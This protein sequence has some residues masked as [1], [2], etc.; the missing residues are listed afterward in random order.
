V[1]R[2]LLACCLLLAV[3][4][5]GPQR[6]QRVLLIG[7][8]LTLA[9]GLGAMIEA[10]AR[11]AGDPPI[12][13]RT[14]AIGGYS[15]ED[16]WTQGEARR[17]LAAGGWS[18]V[19]LQ[20]GPSSLP[21]SRDLLREYAGRF[22]VRVRRAGARTALFMVWPPAA[23]PG[24]YA[25]V[26]QS[27]R[28]A[29]ADVHGLLLPVGDAFRAALEK[30]PRTPL[31]GTDGFHPSPLGTYLAAVVIYQ[32]LAHRPEPFVSPT[33]ESPDGRFPAIVLSP[34][35]VALF[36]AAARP[37]PPSSRSWRANTCTASGCFQC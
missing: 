29:A 31:F 23:G 33:L 20:Q 30:D 9:N 26:S 14:V 32:A 25:Q 22:D 1:R 18:T 10:L 3:A 7:N 2:R 5:A 36:T 15:L 17:A 13:T 4:G 6:G 16:H 21:E 11:A 28:S 24:T 8:S 37:I 19:V 35:T 27:Y 12:E 34:E